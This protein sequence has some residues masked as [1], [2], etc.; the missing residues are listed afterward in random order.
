MSKIKI[1]LSI[2]GDN[3]SVVIRET[4]P[5]E[6]SDILLENSGGNRTYLNIPDLSIYDKNRTISVDVYR[7]EESEND[8][9]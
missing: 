4:E 9:K 2:A 3:G 6:V 1:T 7:V 8:T 5:V